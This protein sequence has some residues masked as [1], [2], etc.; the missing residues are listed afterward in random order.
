MIVSINLAGRA[1][2]LAGLRTRNPLETPEQLQRRLANLWLGPEL[3]AS[4]Y[5]R[6]T[7]DERA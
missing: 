5:G 4:A 6:S 3:A 7:P 2:A 1:L